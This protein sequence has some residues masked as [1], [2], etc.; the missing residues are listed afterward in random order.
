VIARSLSTLDRAMLRLAMTWCRV[1]QTR[2]AAA[3]A[4]WWHRPALANADRWARRWAADPANRCS[5]GCTR[6]HG[7]SR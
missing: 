7:D 5:P 2:P 4:A 6:C 1:T 3:L